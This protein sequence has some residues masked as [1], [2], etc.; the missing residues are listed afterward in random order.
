[1]LDSCDLCLA[2][3]NVEQCVA[4]EKTPPRPSSLHVLGNKAVRRDLQP[5]N[6]LLPIFSM[7]VELGS[8]T[9]KDL[10]PVKSKP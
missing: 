3:V 7:D 2:Q 9:A 4:R 1:M 10:W 8:T 5:A 6:V